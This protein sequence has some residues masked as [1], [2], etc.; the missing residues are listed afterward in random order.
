MKV[1]HLMGSLRPSGMERMFISAAPYFFSSKCEPVIVGQGSEHSYLAPLSQAGY[2]V[3]TI[4]SIRSWQ[5]MAAWQRLLRR[6]RPDVIHIHT[7]GAFGASVLVAKAALPKVPVIRT[8]HNVFSPRGKARV[9]RFIQAKL[10]DWAVSTF[11]AVSPDVQ[12]NERKLGR[13][14]ELIFNWV[15][16]QFFEARALRKSGKSESP[17]AV[18]V[19][20]ASKIK[21]HGLALRAVVENKKVSL[22]YHG[23]ETAATRE[24]KNLLDQ[25]ASE[26]RLL[27]RG[28]GDPL[29]SLVKASVFLLPSKHEGMPIALSEAL[30]VGVPAIINDVPGVQ[31][32]KEFPNV[33]S[34]SENSREWDEAMT[35][36]AE[37]SK[38]L[39]VNQGLLL[40]L[41]ARRGVKELLSVYCSVWTKVDSQ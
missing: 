12:D 36:L 7:E 2:R 21:N 5:G 35:I 9:S 38:S 19:G 41:S 13:S 15:D 28:V 39:G 37:G 4:E 34:I 6:E 40:D 17:T 1:V 20:N 26:G 16:D 27:Y 11:I 29:E 25:L 18:I 31:W 3:E 33:L 10:A 24:E 23:D 8:V 14:A 32:A 22:Y 30:V